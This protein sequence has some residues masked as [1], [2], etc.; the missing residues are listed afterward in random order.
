MF[1]DIDYEK[2]MKNYKIELAK[3]NRIIITN[4]SERTGSSLSTSLGG[5]SELTFQ[6]PYKIENEYHEFVHN[7]NIDLLKEKM[8]LRLTVGNQKSWFI[9]DNI[10]DETL[11]TDMMTVQ[12]FSIQS[13]LKNKRVTERTLKSVNPVMLMDELLVDSS[14]SKGNVD[15]ILQET[16]RTIELA[17]TTIYDA[18]MNGAE[19]FGAIIVWDEETKTVNFNELDSIGSYR[20]MSVNSERFLNNLKRTR[21]TDEMVTRLYVYGNERISIQNVNPSGL[22]YIEDFSYFVE[23]FTRDA[24]KNVITHSAYM[25]DELCHAL[26]DNVELKEQV[27]PQIDSIQEEIQSLNS[28]LATKYTNLDE[29]KLSIITTKGLLDIAKATGDKALITQRQQELSLLESKELSDQSEINSILSQIETNTNTMVSLQDSVAITAFTPELLLELDSYIIEKEFYDDRY[30][31]ETELYNAGIK[32]FAEMR[33]PKVVVDIGIKN[34]LNIVEEQYYWD[35]I[36]LGDKIRIKYPSMKIDYKSTI[37][38]LDFDLDN[39]DCTVKIAN[40]TGNLDSVDKLVSIIYNSQATSLTVSNN[41]YKWNSILVVK[42]RVDQLRDGEIDAVKNRITAGV[43]ESVNIGDS[44]I[45]LTNPDFPEEMVIMQAGV[46]ALTRDGGDTWN[47]SVTPRG[48]V[49]ETIIG[50]LIAGEEL[51]ITNSSGTFVMDSTGLTINSENIFIES[52]DSETPE[53]L[54]EKWNSMVLTMSEFSSDNL[55][56]KYEKQ[57]IKKQWDKIFVVHTSMLTKYYSE[58]G[59]DTPEQPYPIEYHTYIAKF[60]A[61]DAYLNTAIQSDG[62]AILNTANMEK[63]TEID[64]NVYNTKLSE[65]NKA[66]EDFQ[67]VIPMEY[68]KSSIRVLETGIT[69]DYVKNSE[70]VAKIN[71]SEDGVR[72]DGKKIT[73]DGETEFNSDLVM[74]AGLIRSADGAI[75]IDLNNGYINLSRPLTINYVEVATKEQL[76]NIAL[77]PGEKGDKG[78]DGESSYLWIAYS[79]NSDGSN[80]TTSPTNALYVGIAKTTINV[81]PTTASSYKWSKIKGDQGIEG[82]DGD[83]SYIHIK[84]SN[85]GGTTFTGNNG[86]D[87]G[88]YIGTYT[89]F[90]EADSPNVSSYTWS[91]IKGDKGD[92]GDDAKLLF[93]STDTENM[94]FDYAGTANPVNQVAK[95]TI[96]LQNI[97]G[98]ATVTATAYNGDSALPDSITFSRVG[99][100]VTFYVSNFPTTATRVSFTASLNGLTDTVSVNKIKHGDKGDIGD[101]GE[102]AVVGYLT[103][104]SATLGADVNGNIFSYATA[105][106]SFKVFDGLTDVSESCSFNKVS[107]VNISGLINSSGVYTV[108]EMTDENASVTFSATYNS[109]TINKTF[110]ISKSRTGSTGSK[111]DK[112]DAGDELYLWVMYADDINGN[113]IS[114]SSAGKRYLGLSQNNVTITPSNIPSDY[115]WSPLYDNVKVGVENMLFKSDIAMSTSNYMVQQYDMTEK[116][117]AGEMYALRLWGTLGVGK[118]HFEAYLN[119]GGISLSDLSDNGDGTYSAIFVGKDSGE[120]TGDYIQIYAKDSAVVVDSTIEKI[121]LEKGTIHTGYN[122]AVKDISSMINLKADADSVNTLSQN[123]SEMSKILE[124]KMNKAEYSEFLESYEKFVKGYNDDKLQISSDKSNLTSRTVALEENLGGMSRKWNF[125][126]SSIQM[127]DEGMLISGVIYDEARDVNAPTGMEILLTNNQISFLDN[128]TVVAFISGKVLQINHGIFVKSMQVGNHLMHSLASNPKITVFSY[129]GEE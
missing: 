63:T 121:K 19:T 52:G 62:Y 117:I 25:S 104:E 116:M 2:K 97:T 94:T 59:A 20:G 10:S 40:Y 22:R 29:T 83:T 100:V 9:V 54:I 92:T 58:V 35:K 123:Y 102:N 26:L 72:I 44:G 17:D 71:L 11:D 77:T 122:T 14:W 114:E 70:V 69:L 91:K 129:V 118:T 46:I 106:G 27:L 32:K 50:N 5:L 38:G 93:L 3:P 28:S 86:E 34:L 113:G 7:P 66:K 99:D 31:D 24:N 82:D 16:Y 49:A 1:I 74:N 64:P 8:Y 90:I 73:I 67:L 127:A 42:D 79:Q 41:K 56:N 43:N 30:I 36:V 88:T 6:I 126:D 55:L 12:A 111:G 39:M 112:G 115:V 119:G 120:T 84:Y 13:E 76:D 110:T 108:S 78:D 65:F 125:V 51:V 87:S 53:N 107:Q 15:S 48:V 21:D 57:Q 18:L 89:D 60:D 124:Q 47:T 61:L 128:D 98:T 101:T 81:A 103:N 33:Q 23:P 37:I 75:N 80:F 95:I 68:A 109:V 96:K 4:L 85:D 45:I 105:T